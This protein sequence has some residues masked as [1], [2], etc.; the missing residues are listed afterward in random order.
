[1]ADTP[2]DAAGD[3]SPAARVPGA[4]PPGADPFARADA[5]LY[6]V[7]LWPHRSLTQRG[8]WRVLGLLAAGLALPLLSVWGTPVAWALSPFLLGALAL[9]WWALSR[10]LR[11]GRL[12][13]TLRLWPD[14]IAVERREPRGAVRRWAANPHWVAVEVADTPTVPRYL[15]LRG[16]GRT[17]ELGAFLAPEE[18]ER[19]A[20]DLRAALGRARAAAV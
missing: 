6:A 7:T 12:R 17:I 4:L 16:A 18:R 3:A 2:A 11:E 8:L 15:T 10:N 5:P 14:A 9:L 20:A 1:M 13:E 19:L